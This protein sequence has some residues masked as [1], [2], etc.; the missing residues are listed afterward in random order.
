MTA[1]MSDNA[2]DATQPQVYSRVKAPVNDTAPKRVFA[3]DYDDNTP[4]SGIGDY[5][6]KGRIKLK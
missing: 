6:S 3:E 5:M 2:K 4:S 1:V